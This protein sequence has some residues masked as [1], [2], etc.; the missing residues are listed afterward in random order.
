MSDKYFE[1]V[2]KIG[3]LYFEQELFSFENIPIIFVC[4][5]KHD[6][7][8]LCVCDDVID[9]ESWII[10]K[11]M[12]EELLSVLCDENSV[13]SVYKN[14][15]VIVVNKPFGETIEYIETQYNKINQDELPLSDQYL[16]MKEYLS[17]YIRK[18]RKSIFTELFL[19]F[20]CNVQNEFDFLQYILNVIISQKQPNQNKY[21]TNDYTNINTLTSHNDMSFKIQ[22]E[23]EYYCNLEQKEWLECNSMIYAA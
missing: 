16:D 9:E 19:S 22:F 7:R 14:K 11:V 13:L 6:N 12:N 23:S 20:D 5:D 10:V 15:Q 1:N 3:N 8:Y 4:I 2:P 21:D 17:D 18:I